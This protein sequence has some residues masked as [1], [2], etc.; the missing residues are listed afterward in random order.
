[1]GL[2][3]QM[4]RVYQDGLRGKFTPTKT[5][6]KKIDPPILKNAAG[7]DIIE[8]KRVTLTGNPNSITQL[9]GNKGGIERNYYDE[10]GRQYKQISNN[11][12][13][14]A[15]RH[16]YGN[17]GEHAH[18]Y[19]YKDDKLISATNYYYKVAAYKEV[20]GKDYVGPTTKSLKATTKPLQP[21]VKLSS[22]SKGKVKLT[23]T[24]KVS[25]KTDGYKI[26]MS[27]SKNGVYKLLKDT[28]KTTYNKTGLKSKKG[29]YFKVRAYRAVDGKNVYSSYS[30]AKYIKV[31]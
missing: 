28:E 11:D 29:Y 18:D 15:K 17:K 6:L 19:V 21:V 7:K 2:P 20:D 4:K 22:T 24:T 14:N 10:N 25:K 31:K 12:H 30:T 8:V 16:P 23:Y 5:E 3:E 27:T 9:T 26:Y 1:M 13:G